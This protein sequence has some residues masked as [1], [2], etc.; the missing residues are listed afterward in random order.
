VESF[1]VFGQKIGLGFQIRD[2]IL[3]IW[4]LSSETGKPSG[5]DIRRRKKS[6]PVI[7]AL[8]N[9]QGEQREKLLEI[10]RREDPISPEEEQFVFQALEESGAK[11][12]AQQQADLMKT[13]ALA[14]LDS[15]ISNPED[16]QP[17]TLLR[18]L[19]TFL[20]ERSF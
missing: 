11:D 19:C 20:V 13:E 10:Y 4:G 12:Y 1:A 8:S 7:Y 5:S 2:D 17:L 3:G 9:S 14:A 18:N 15:A 16:N 6:L